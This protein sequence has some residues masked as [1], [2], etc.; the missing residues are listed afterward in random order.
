LIIFIEENGK[1]GFLGCI[2]SHETQKGNVK[3]KLEHFC[4]QDEE[5]HDYEVKY[6]DSYLVPHKFIK[7]NDWIKNVNVVG[8]LTKEGIK[9]M[10]DN[11]DNIP[12]EAIFT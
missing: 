9:F 4:I 5:G 2:I 6:D 11:I 1:D 3:M 12:N 7:M 10:I 8:R